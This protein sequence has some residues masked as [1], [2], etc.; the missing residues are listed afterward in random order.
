MHLLCQRIED[1]QDGKKVGKTS[2]RIA[3]QL[4]GRAAR[5]ASGLCLAR[6]HPN[7]ACS[8]AA[9]PHLGVPFAVASTRRSSGRHLNRLW[10]M[11]CTDSVIQQLW[12]SGPTSGPCSRTAQLYTTRCITPGSL[13]GMLDRT[14]AGPCQG[15][16]GARRWWACGG[17]IGRV[18]R[19]MVGRPAK[20][21]RDD[22]KPTLHL[23]SVSHTMRTLCT[24]L[25]RSTLPP[26]CTAA[27]P[28]GNSGCPQR[29][30]QAEPSPRGSS[31]V[32]APW[33]PV[34]NSGCPKRSPQAEPRPSRLTH[35]ENRQVW[36]HLNRAQHVCGLMIQQWPVY[37]ALQAG[38]RRRAAQA[39]CGLDSRRQL[40]GWRAGEVL[41]AAARSHRSSRLVLKN[42][43]VASNPSPRPTPD[44]A[45]WAKQ[46][47]TW[48][49]SA[50]SVP[51][52]SPHDCRAISAA[53]G[54][55]WRHGEEPSSASTPA[56]STLPP[57]AAS[58]QS[59]PPARWPAGSAGMQ[60]GTPPPRP[61][62]AEPPAVPVPRHQG[63]SRAQAAGEG[64]TG[65]A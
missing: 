14:P 57:P 59:A 5:G 15:G 60:S 52:P 10:L 24:A 50:T 4:T 45:C 54:A 39:L 2:A 37:I 56:L 49:A 26:M 28:D 16:G 7:D 12:N 64:K 42:R 31:T 35:Y 33:L 19:S 40:V 65:G 30:P 46:P 20:D 36:L 53:H 63:P 25:G 3:E 27:L 38:G 9:P 18:Q 8:N 11:G 17:P 32:C 41:L 48:W 6:K 61:R 34:G 22:S 47:D 29:S 1:C 62:P 55:S 51:H 13:V 58:P 43:D 21:H 44:D 23:N